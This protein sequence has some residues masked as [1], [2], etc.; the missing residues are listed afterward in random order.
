MTDAL[1][2]T[3]L[4]EGVLTLTLN[5]ADKLNAMS[6]PMLDALLAALDQADTDDEVRA[7]IL[8]GSGRG[9]CAGTDLSGGAETFSASKKTDMDEHRDAGGVL[10]LRIFDLLKPVIAAI[11][12]PATGV[13]ITMTL[14]CDVRIASTTARMGFVFVRRGI[15][16]DA[17]SSW[18]APRIVGISQAAQWFMSGRVFDATEALQGGLVK[19]LV[20]PEALLARAHEIARQ[21]VVDTSQVSVAVT[22]RLL[23]RMLGA[24][25][26]RDAFSQESKTL[27]YMGKGMDSKEGV[28]SFLEKRAPEFS[29]RV[30]RDFPDFL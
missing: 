28:T 24:T 25:N 20:A 27:W 10:A 12:G 5:R 21:F 26:P 3:N 1:I 17:C 29:M 6:Y 16:P 30:A 8:T 7:I 9:F 11:N 4:R 2:L 15:A 14:P 19:E 22:R 13:G 18:F 23:W